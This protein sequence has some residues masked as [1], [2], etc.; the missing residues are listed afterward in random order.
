MKTVSKTVF[1]K[2][3]ENKQT[4]Y[5]C[6]KQRYSMNTPAVVSIVIKGPKKKTLIF[7]F[8]L[9]LKTKGIKK[10]KRRNEKDLC[11][12]S[13]LS[14]VYFL[15]FISFLFFFASKGIKNDP[16]VIYGVACCGKF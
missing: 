15:F 8:S 6:R 10:E 5:Y 9:V 3:P 16:V 4:Y 13:L 14:F 11:F 2:T 7:F 12:N 1:I